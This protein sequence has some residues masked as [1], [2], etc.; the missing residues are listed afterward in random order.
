MNS[1]TKSNGA[2]LYRGASQLDGAPI[3]VIVTGLKNASA[4][5]KTGDMLQTWILRDDISPTDAVKS[6]ADAS[7]CGDCPLR[8]INGKSRGCYVTLHQAPLSV[9]KAFKRGNYPVVALEDISRLVAGRMLRLGSYGDPAAVPA[10]IWTAATSKV[11]GWTGYTHQWR[12]TPSLKSLCMASADNEQQRAEAVAEGW[13][14]FR[15]KAEGE[16]ILKGEVMC[17]A[18]TVGLS[19]KD[20]GACKGAG[21]RQTGTIV[22]NIH[23]SKGTINAGLAALAAA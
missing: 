8:G 20:C 18:T 4:N 6:G 14:T 15:V 12:T 11:S 3:V 22:I 10:N 7:I 19:C 17:P 2:I 16:A 5:G 13:R 21:G 23:G 1:L 9:Y